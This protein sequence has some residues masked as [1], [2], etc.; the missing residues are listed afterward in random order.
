MVDDMLNGVADGERLS[1]R[2]TGVPFLPGV[3]GADE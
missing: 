1:R 2:G 3:L